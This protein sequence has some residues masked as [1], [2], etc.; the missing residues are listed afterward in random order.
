MFVPKDDNVKLCKVTLKNN[1]T[2]DR[3]L[4]LTYYAQTVLGVVPQHTSIH[5]ATSLNN[6]KKYI[7]AQNPYS[8][9]FGNL[10]AYLKIVGGKEE[11]FTGDRKEFIGRGKS[12]ENPEALKRVRL[13]NT[14]GGGYDPCLCENVKFTIKQGEEQ[15]LVIMLGEDE[16][17]DAVEKVIGKYED[18]K[19]VEEELN[20]VK[21]YWRNL[22]HTIK[23]K[24]PDKT[25]DIM[26]NGWLLYQT[27]VCRIWARSAFY[28][29]GGAYG[30]RDQ[31]QDM[32]AVAY[33][34]P[35][36]T[37][38]HIVYSASRQFLKE[39]YSTGGIQELIV[40]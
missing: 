23:V 10:H 29:S 28:Q 37:R 25:M 22:L 24:T 3:R 38:E 32:M 13:S 39:M 26:L 15:T 35:N 11:S 14:T 27:I 34:D 18:I 12:I 40:V 6:N 7:S 1:S 20:I 2:M 9:H 33:V 17:I 5:I 16:S 21:D 30:F 19:K 4:S 8:E 36:M 31:L